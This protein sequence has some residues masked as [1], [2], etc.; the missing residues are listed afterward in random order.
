MGMVGIPSVCAGCHKLG[1]NY[2]V[3][4]GCGLRYCPGCATTL[5]ACANCGGRLA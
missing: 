1:T 2:S 3:C 5:M 4:R